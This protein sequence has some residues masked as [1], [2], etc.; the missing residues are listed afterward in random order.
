METVATKL[1]KSGR[2]VLPAHFRRALGIETG[3]ELISALD[4][5]E[6]RIFTRAKA[7]KRAQGLVR[8]YI[9]GGRSLVDELI[10]ERRTESARE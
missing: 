6:L 7:I 4:E 1:G 3:D 5:G 2:L 8:G 9:P 10:E